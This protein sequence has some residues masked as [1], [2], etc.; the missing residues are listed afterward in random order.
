[1]SAGFEQLAVWTRAR[2][3]CG[4]ILPVLRAARAASDYE[5]A[6]QLNRSAISIMSNIAEGH[7]RRGRRQFAHFLGIAAGSN[8]EARSCLY[9]ALDRLYLTAPEFEALCRQT[10]EMG[11]MLEALRA[12]V[13]RQVSSGQAPTSNL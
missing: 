10:N 3:F 12:A 2:A 5:L 13:L 4:A 1:M 8:G 7:L 11:R 9:L 6:Q